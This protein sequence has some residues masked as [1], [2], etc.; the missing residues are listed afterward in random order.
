LESTLIKPQLKPDF[1]FLS[2]R[3]YE[4]ATI[5]IRILLE[6]LKIF[7]S[8]IGCGRLY[9]DT[10][11]PRDDKRDARI[12][13]WVHSLGLEDYVEVL[14]LDR[15][16]MFSYMQHCDCYVSASRADGLPLSLLESLFFGQTPIV[17]NH[18][19]TKPLLEQFESMICFETHDPRE[20]AKCWELAY[21]RRPTQLADVS[22]QRKKVIELYSRNR[23]LREIA[24][25]YSS[26]GR[27]P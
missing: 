26:L 10:H 14:H 9:I 12:R 15:L 17:F 6:A 2:V 23:G 20:I 24:E 8:K 3:G 27:Q 5:R 22:H 19:S 4:N 16:A 7:R 1:S 21:R 25:I 11:Q 18:E 13:S